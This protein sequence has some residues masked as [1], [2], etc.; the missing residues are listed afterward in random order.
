[1]LSILSTNNCPLHL[2]GP[3]YVKVIVLLPCL[4]VYCQRSAE[5]QQTTW[6]NRAVALA[7]FLCSVRT[8]TQKATRQTEWREH[9]Y[10]GKE[11]D[12][13]LSKHTLTHKQN[14]NNHTLFSSSGIALWMA[15][16]VNW[17]VNLFGSDWKNCMT[18]GYIATNVDTDHIGTKQFI[19][20]TLVIP[21]PFLYH[22]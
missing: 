3:L 10:T 13:T 6:K 7:F 18:I 2:T 4:W 15:M 12:E 21:W 17:L 9:K 19:L 20:M 14:A 5:Q 11:K 16:F 1:M 8:R 22:Q